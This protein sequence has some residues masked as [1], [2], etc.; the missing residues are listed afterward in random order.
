MDEIAVRLGDDGDAEEALRSLTR[1]VHE[2]ES[3]G[4]RV[5]GRILAD[6]APEPGSMGTGFDLVQFAV[7]S[8]MSA[9]AVVVSVL[10]WRSSL[11]KPPGLTLTRNGVEVQVS[12]ELAADDEVLRRLVAALDTDGDGSP[13]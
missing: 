12:A 11:R 7:G 8:G 4:G 3:L 13:R 1:W 6:A 9:A 2:D 10:Q 5:R